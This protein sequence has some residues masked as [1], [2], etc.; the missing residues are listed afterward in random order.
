VFAFGCGASRWPLAVL[1]ADWLRSKAR[2]RSSLAQVGFPVRDRLARVRYKLCC[3]FQPPC[4]DRSAC[5]VPQAGSVARSP[6]TSLRP[7]VPSCWPASP[8]QPWPTDAPSTSPAMDAG[9]GRAAKMQHL[10]AL[11]LPANDNFASFTDRMDL[12]HRLRDVQSDCANL[13]LFCGTSEQRNVAHRNAGGGAAHTIK[14]D[15]RR[16]G[17]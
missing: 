13:L 10:A 12:E 3:S 11:Q 2:A 1:S 16:V 8:R 14:A 9:G 4:V 7:C 17:R 5:L 15:V 6:P